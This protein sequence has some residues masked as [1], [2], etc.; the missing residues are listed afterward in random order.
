MINAIMQ[1]WKWGFGNC[2]F[3]VVAQTH[4]QKLRELEDGPL[5]R[6]SE[7]IMDIYPKFATFGITTK[8]YSLIK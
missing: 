4:V 2:F 3:V 7:L 1:T 6:C 5:K 8:W